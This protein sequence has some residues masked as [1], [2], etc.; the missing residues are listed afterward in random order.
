MMSK[1]QMREI[2]LPRRL[3]RRIE[4]PARYLGGEWN[5]ISKEA[6]L[7]DGRPRLRFAFCF[8]DIYE[9][10]M[11]NLALRILYD[12]LNRRDD[13]LCER[14]FEP[15]TDLRE[16]MIRENIPLFS[17]ENGRVLKDFD[18]VG[19]TLQYE[20]SFPTV[21]DM[22]NLG[23]IPL[24]Q[25]DRG[26][27]DPLVVAGGPVVFN[28]EPV[29]DFFDL[30]MIGEGEELLPEV[31][32]CYRKVR[33][34]GGCKA[35]FLKAAAQIEG[36]YVPSFYEAVYEEDGRF[37][38]LKALKDFVPKRPVKRIVRDLDATSAPEK[39]LVPHIEI[40][41]DRVFLELY[42]GCGN[43]CRFCQAGMIYR[44][45]REN[46]AE[47]LVNRARAML[48]SSGYE[49]LGL[50]SLST[51]DYS[52]LFPLIEA[53]LPE[54]EESHVNLSLPSLRLDSVSM[55]LLD[56]V[57][58][59]RKAG[60]TFAPEAGSQM[61]RDRINKN[62]QE[63]DL[64]TAAREAFIKGWDRL[65]LYFMLG[66]P[67]ETDEDIYGI[68]DLC[69]KLLSL[70]QE[71]REESA[72]PR[73]KLIITVSTSFFI[74]KPWTPFQYVAQ[75]S[76]LEMERRQGLLAS[77]LK[78]RRLSYQW[79]DFDTSEIEALL[80]RGDRRLSRV[81]LHVVEEGAFMEGE[82]Q[83]FSYERWLRALSREGLDLDFFA[84][85][86]RP[87][88]ENFPWDFIETGLKKSFLWQEYQRGLEGQCSPDCRKGC[89]ACG[90][91]SY[92][93]AICLSEK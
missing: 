23:G 85:R 31:M 76:R 6:N 84:H 58:R 49:E 22:L 40:V 21:L 92:R 11:S 18:F 13:Q 32:D 57:S 71:V 48:A 9:V 65:K 26:E 16:I 86:E 29:A 73:R 15:G 12:L 74:P 19:F 50:M 36:V 41:H 63:S 20:M 91:S 62:I 89:R 52:E 4:K 17:V 55:E 64:L 38:E 90:A 5:S 61:A 51:G 45:L 7:A 67:G 33:T 46:S 47:T 39:V 2:H 77:L 78:D 56:R 82:R 28:A 66:L 72:G 1:T 69:K 30:I 35:D 79:H 37:R 27:E 59:T 93:A 83:N 44:P 70:W 87:E 14:F 24:L 25:K 8:P 34:E 88:D 53:L 3:L 80:A 81:L 42:R 54:L 10:G 68:A 43:G 60:L 75:I